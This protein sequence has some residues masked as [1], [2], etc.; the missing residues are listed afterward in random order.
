MRFVRFPTISL[1]FRRTLKVAISDLKKGEWIKYHSKPHHIVLASS[2]QSGR[3]SR[4]YSLQL[5][6]VDSDSIITIRPYSTE[7]FELTD[8]YD[9]S[10]RFQYDDEENMYLSNDRTLEEITVPKR[11][12]NPAL[13]NTLEPGQMLRVRFEKDGTLLHIE[14]TRSVECTVVKVDLLEERKGI[15]TLQSGLQVAVPGFIKPG[16]RITV[17]TVDRTYVTRAD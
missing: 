6:P 3:N 17:N 10:F 14:G 7:T 5:K 16:D 13:F 9:S 8:V 4:I 2:V 11:L 1:L 15:V 12:A